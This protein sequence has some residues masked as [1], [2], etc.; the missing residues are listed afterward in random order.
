MGR[1]DEDEGLVWQSA[2]ITPQDMAAAGF[3]PSSTT[4]IRFTALDGGFNNIVEAGVDGVQIIR[5]GCPSPGDVNVDGTVN[6][7][8]LTQVLLFWGPCPGCPADLD[9][10][11]IVNLT[12]LTEVLLNW[13]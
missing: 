3:T 1:H 13:G 2:E 7:T 5:R 11:D 6:L 10:D 9:G 12:D 8:D 4:R